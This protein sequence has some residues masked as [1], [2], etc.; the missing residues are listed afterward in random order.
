MRYKAYFILVFSIETYTVFFLIPLLISMKILESEV[1]QFMKLYHPVFW[2]LK[3][4]L[5]FCS[6]VLLMKMCFFLSFEVIL[7]YLLN[8]IW[9]K[10]TKQFLTKYYQKYYTEN[11]IYMSILYHPSDCKKEYYIFPKDYYFT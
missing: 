6:L 8:N 1:L 5:V 2:K 10:I 7:N 11:L 4:G 3:Y 9:H